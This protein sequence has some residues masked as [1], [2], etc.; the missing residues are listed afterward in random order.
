MNHTRFYKRNILLVIHKTVSLFPCKPFHIVQDS[1][2]Y[3][4]AITEEKVRFCSS[5]VSSLCVQGVC[6]FFTK[7]Q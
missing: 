5:L 7:H 4:F 2:R 1:L 6:L 3:R